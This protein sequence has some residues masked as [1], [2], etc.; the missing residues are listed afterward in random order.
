VKFSNEI[1]DLVYQEYLEIEPKA[2]HDR[3]RFFECNKK[4]ISKLSY[5]Q[6]LEISFEYTIALFEVGEY[7]RFLKNVD[8]L[9]AICINDNI[10][11]NVDGE[12]IYQDLLFKKACALHNT[13]DFVSADHVF[14]ELIRINK[15]NHTYQRAYSRNKI[16]LLRDSGQRIRAI[17]IS[18]FLSTGLII[19]FELLVVRPFFESHIQLTEYTR[20]GLFLAAI[21]TMILQELY[22]RFTSARS[23]KALTTKS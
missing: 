1:S 8:Q 11:L 20:N 4:G 2:Y 14:S 18:M 3:I 12:D 22:I 23:I 6:R 21:A 13:V 10:Y 5:E 17:V 9:L 7:T 16:L 19:G 15:T